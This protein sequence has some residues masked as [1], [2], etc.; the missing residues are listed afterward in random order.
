MAT[1]CHYEGEYQAQQE[2]KQRI[3][4]MS[5]IVLL[6][7]I[8]LL[9]GYYR[10]WTLVA[11]ILANLPIALVGGILY[12]RYTL[13]NISIATLV[14]LIA[15]CG[16]CAR[17]TILLISHY[18]HLLRNEGQV[19]GAEMII[20]GTQERLV[21]ILMTALSKGI[22]LVPLLLA[23]DEAGKEILHPVAIVI[24]AGGLVSST[25]L[26]LLLTPAVFYA[27]CQKAA[28]LSIERTNPKKV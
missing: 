21:P 27:F 9:H 15:V 8:V 12:T 22:A 2:S 13:D 18:L 28:F 17:N 16:I 11:L 3:F 4:W 5:G 6:V 26:G 23:N 10:S 24:V 7:M 25:I 19:F 20:R 1:H 14:G